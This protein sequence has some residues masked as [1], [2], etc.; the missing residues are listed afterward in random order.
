MLDASDTLKTENTD[1]LIV[2]S[3]HSE[4]TKCVH[5][6]EESHSAQPECHFITLPS[7][8]WDSPLKSF[9][10][11]C[12]SLWTEPQSYY[13]CHIPC[14]LHSLCNDVSNNLLMLTAPCD[15]IF[16]LWLAVTQAAG[17]TSAPAAFSPQELSDR[18]SLCCRARVIEA[19]DSSLPLY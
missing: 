13:S 7:F 12:I 14:T 3:L 19:G 11:P 9:K 8:I 1:I 16:Y 15:G 5:A 10:A 17:V 6:S 18:E 2:E 4:V